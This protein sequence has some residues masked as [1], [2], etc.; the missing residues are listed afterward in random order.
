M[1][2]LA[3]TLL[4]ASPGTEGPAQEAAYSEVTPE[5]EARPKPEIPSENTVA[6]ETHGLLPAAVTWRDGFSLR[7]PDGTMQLLIGGR[8]HNDWLVSGADPALDAR[9][10]A[11]NDGATFAS[12]VRFR[13]AR[14]NLQGKL[15]GRVGFR[16]EFEFAEGSQTESTDTYL[17]VEDL[18]GLG[19]LRIGNFK[20]PFSF[21]FLESSNVMTFQEFSLA[22]AFSPDR[23]SGIGFNNTIADRFHY[24]AGLFVETSSFRETRIRGAFAATTRLAAILYQDKARRLLAQAAIAFRYERLGQ[25]ALRFS[26]VSGSTLAPL[27]FD[28]G[29]IDGEETYAFD[30]QLALVAGPFDLVAEGVGVRAVLT[31]AQT[32]AYWG[33][34][35]S[36]GWFLTGES[37]PFNPSSM[38][39]ARLRPNRNV[40]QG[41]PGAIQLGVRWSEVDL[42]GPSNG[43]RGSELTTIVSWWLNPHARF[44]TA[45]VRTN[46]YGLGQA[47]LGQARIQFDF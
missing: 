10:A 32:P 45:Y 31:R 20:E 16:S 5:G 27:T 21:A 33:Y 17:E 23:N 47:N 40:F 2:T 43:G 35:V 38:L 4:A 8:V 12:G 14:I 41:G 26:V 11:L 28:T 25:T 37:R 3:L 34:F 18:P 7:T 24:A 22:H 36:L 19:D 15:Y 30:G 39:F 1:L 46:L 44:S 9:A 29:N 42:D 13:R 6:A